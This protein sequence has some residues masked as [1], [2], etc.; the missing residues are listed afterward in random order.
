MQPGVQPS[1]VQILW[2]HF[3]TPNDCTLGVFVRDFLALAF[4]INDLP[5]VFPDH[6]RNYHSKLKHAMLKIGRI[7]S[8]HTRVET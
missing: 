5:I 4:E 3:T 6:F 1:V 8:N 7:M 2:L